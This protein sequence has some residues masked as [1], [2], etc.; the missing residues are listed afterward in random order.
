ML[1]ADFIPVLEVALFIQGVSR[2][3]IVHQTIHRV[4]ALMEFAM[5]ATFRLLGERKWTAQNKSKA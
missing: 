2:L 4:F 1:T 3:G 5:N